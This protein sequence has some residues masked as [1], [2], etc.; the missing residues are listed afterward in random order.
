MKRKEEFR[1]QVEGCPLLV[2]QMTLLDLTIFVLGDNC[3]D[4]CG[5]GITLSN[6]RLRT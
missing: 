3:I 5:S 4:S 6:Q 2:K 1:C